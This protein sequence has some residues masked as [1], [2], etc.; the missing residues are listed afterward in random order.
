MLAAAALVV[1]GVAWARH[2]PALADALIELPAPVA[3]RCAQCAWIESKREVLPGTYEYTTRMVDGSSS[4]FLETMPVTWR[5]GE[6]LVL[7]GGAGR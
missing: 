1:L 7:I 3:R 6:R 4:V 5:V 2:A